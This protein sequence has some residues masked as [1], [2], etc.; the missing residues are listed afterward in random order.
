MMILAKYS[1]NPDHLREF[2][3]GTMREEFIT[4]KQKYEQAYKV[5]YKAIFNE[6]L[7]AY[8]KLG[9]KVTIVDAFA[10]FNALARLG[11]YKEKEEEVFKRL[12]ATQNEADIQD[13][14]EFLPLRCV[15][16]IIANDFR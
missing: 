10:A 6:V 4:F 11:I 8:E 12:M 9:E 7:K 3:W 2:M 16:R 15:R 5:R 13:L 14:K 1:D